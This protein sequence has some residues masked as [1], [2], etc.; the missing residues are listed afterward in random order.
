MKSA[1][2]KN[3]SA[4]WVENKEADGPK[5]F[6]AAGVD[7]GAKQANR[8]I[9]VPG[10]GGDSGNR[11]FCGRGYL[12][13]FHGH[14]AIQHVTFHL[15]DSLP[16]NTLDRL[17]REIEVCPSNRRNAELRIKIEDWIDSGAG[18]CIL[19][20]PEIAVMVQETLL[21]FHWQRYELIAWTVMPNHVHVLFQP[22]NGWSLPKIVASWKKFTAKNIHIFR[23]ARPGHANLPIGHYENEGESSN[24]LKRNAK[25]PSPDPVWHREY[26][27]LYIRNE[28]HFQQAIEYIHMN[29]VKA[30]LVSRPE[31]WLWSSANSQSGDWRARRDDFGKD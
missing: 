7:V 12:H 18:S 9:G 11:V 1:P 2:H 3:N 25:K 31:D 13:H 19:R 28:R 24:S 30:G 27:D 23:A 22:I 21:F 17:K 26:W 20:E 6:G 16:K 5:G 10:V 8:E 29:P 15:E 14:G 4:I